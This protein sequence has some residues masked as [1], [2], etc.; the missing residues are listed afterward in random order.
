MG[1][2]QGFGAVETGTAFLEM[3]EELANSKMVETKEEAMLYF[4]GWMS[5]RLNEQSRNFDKANFRASA[6]QVI[7]NL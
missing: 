4:A 1:A 6:K 5:N 2:P 7:F 3:L